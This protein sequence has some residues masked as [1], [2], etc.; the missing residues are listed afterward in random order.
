MA[1]SP[2][3]NLT[4]VPG[5]RIS[6][7]LNL[8]WG[9]NKVGACF[10]SGE[11]VPGDTPLYDD[12]LDNLDRNL[13]TIDDVVS[14]VR[15]FLLGNFA[16]LGSTKAAD[17]GP[18]V[19]DD[20]DMMGA[21]SGTGAR[22]PVG[23]RVKPW[24]NFVPPTKEEWDGPRPD[25]GRPYKE[26]YTQQLARMF[27]IFRQH[28]QHGPLKVIPVLT[29]FAGFAQ[30]TPTAGYKTD[31]IVD[32]AMRKWFLDNVVDPFLNVSTSDGN[33][34][35]IYAWDVMNEP[36]QV[37]ES[38]HIR[39]VSKK[40]NF[41][42]S[43]S[44]MNSFLSDVVARI[45]SSG[46]K[47]TVGHHYLGDLQTPALQAGDIPQFHFYPQRTPRD[48]GRHLGVPY[49]L[50]EH[51]DSGAFIGEFQSDYTE[52]DQGDTSIPWPEIPDWDQ[53]GDGKSCTV[54]RLKLIEQ[55]GYGLALLWPDQPT[56]T[57]KRRALPGHL[58][59]L[60]AT[61][62]DEPLHYSQGVLDGIRQYINS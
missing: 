60:E 30:G 3:I 4:S 39:F 54:K 33:D 19:V 62:K 52:P 45:K 16:N 59:Y 7:G 9:W 12:W 29:D 1:K 25:G 36:G 22:V 17:E 15:V 46:L 43:Y 34:Q 24:W 42:I 38:L 10:G 37:T 23:H 47:A 32:P 56:T 41:F 6:V 14:V 26:I 48:I 31:I 28:Q 49:D 40:T 58:N 61:R 21:P 2:T 27:K 20:A 8:P 57:P 13:G 51:K 55:K 53:V 18:F 11:K 5:R 44:T 50:P 35:V